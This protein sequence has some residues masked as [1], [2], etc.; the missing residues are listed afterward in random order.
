[1]TNEAHTDLH[2]RSAATLGRVGVGRHV[3]KDIMDDHEPCDGDAVL[4]V[5]SELLANA[6]LHGG[7]TIDLH[8]EVFEDRTRVEVSDTGAGWPEAQPYDPLSDNGGRGLHIVDQ[9][10]TRWGI[11]ARPIGKRVWCELPHTPP[12]A[13][14]A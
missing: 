13:A 8:V 11:D 4:L 9:L 7:G 14:G 1:M 12:P 6:V 2:L 5:A 3:I 10:A